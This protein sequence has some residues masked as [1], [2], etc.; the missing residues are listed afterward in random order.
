M[1][2][3]AIA[4]AVGGIGVTVTALFGV[5]AAALSVE[6]GDCYCCGKKRPERTPSTLSALSSPT[7]ER[8]EEF[9]MEPSVPE[10]VPRSLPPNLAGLD[11][12]SKMEVL[13]AKRDKQTLGEDP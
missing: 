11:G 8:L 10:E 5:T 9:D 2:F 6:N 12:K 3:L 1:I 4:G 7:R 13:I